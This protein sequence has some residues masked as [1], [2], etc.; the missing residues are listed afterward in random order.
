MQEWWTSR[1]WREG[2][3]IPIAYL[4][5]WTELLGLAAGP[6]RLPLRQVTTEERS[7]LRA[8]LERVGLLQGA[9]APA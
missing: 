2:R 3:V 6:V 4:K 8:D 1:R 5:A 9:A 7:A